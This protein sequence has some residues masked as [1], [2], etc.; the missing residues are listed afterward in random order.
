MMFFG[1]AFRS[2]VWSEVEKCYE[3]LHHANYKSK[4]C[5]SFFS[6]SHCSFEGKIIDSDSL[7]YVDET[8]KRKKLN[9]LKNLNYLF[10]FIENKTGEE[11]FLKKEFFNK[12][13]EHFQNSAS[14]SKAYI[15]VKWNSVKGLFAFRL[16]K[17]FELAL[18]REILLET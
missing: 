6:P 14:L 2:L 18:K 11:K 16:N 3:R 13:F 4:Y 12:S 10:L 7:K 8:N 1:L 15:A 9:Q 5:F 17:L